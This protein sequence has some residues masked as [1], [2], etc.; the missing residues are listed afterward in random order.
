MLQKILAFFM[1]IIAFFGNLF[2]VYK[3][4][5]Y[6]YE[7]LSYGNHERQNL[8]LC[9]SKE[10]EGKSVGL[11]L[12][13]HGGAWIEGDKSTYKLSDLQQV[14]AN[15]KFATAA[16]NYRYI[17]EDTDINDIMDDID[18]ALAK[19]KEVGKEHNVDID[20]VI[21]T[22]YSAGAHLSMLY[23]YS[24]VSEAPIKPVAVVSYCGP[25]N[26]A[27]TNFY[28]NSNLGDEAFVSLLMSYACGQKFTI[29]TIGTAAEALAKVSPVTY[30]NENTVPTIIAHGEKDTTVPFSNAVQLDAL[31]TENGVE[32]EFVVYPNSDHSLNN[33]ADKSKLAGDLSVQYIEKYLK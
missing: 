18:S 31:L 1:A 33:D 28:H 32:H 16:V 17:S 15:N 9:I 6:T 8:N 3:N 20:K 5:V 24:R 21:L 30:V 27:D 14:A 19:I 23:A 2:G 7:N 13:I 4:K 22:G 29:D 10:A 26:L 25:T 11:I 12:N